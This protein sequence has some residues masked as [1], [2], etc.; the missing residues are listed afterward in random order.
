M[1]LIGSFLLLGPVA[2]KAT[3]SSEEMDRVEAATHVFNDFAGSIPAAVLKNAK[4][5][6]IIPGEVKAGFIF[7]G[8]LGQGVLPTRTPNGSSSPPAFIL[9]AGGSIGLRS[10]RE[11]RDI[12]LVFNT[13]RSV[14]Y[15]ENA[16]L[17]LGGDASVTAGPDGGDFEVTSD[18]P[19]VYS[20]VR[21][22]GAFI[23]ATI[24]GS[25]L[26]FDFGENSNF[27]GVSDPLEM[28][29][30]EIPEPARRL[31]CMVSGATNATSEF[32]S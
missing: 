14:E 24:N 31:D 30:I 25:V 12:V 29:A 28:H 6:A 32:C 16:R 22:L 15:I 20:Y 23:G 9:V 5:M 19:E 7:G 21:S 13:A 26:T 3:P 10:G 8:E 4:G 27:Y 11:A 1:G 18:I 17:T 2:V